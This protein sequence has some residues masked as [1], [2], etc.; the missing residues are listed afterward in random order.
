MTYKSG[1]M[2]NETVALAAAWPCECCS[3]FRASQP[4]G[5]TLGPTLAAGEQGK[6][7]TSAMMARARPD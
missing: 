2:E 5:R 6:T 1:D 3:E 7:L 4:E